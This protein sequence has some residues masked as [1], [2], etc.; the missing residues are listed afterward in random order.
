MCTKDRHTHSTA[1]RHGRI[2]GHCHRM[3]SRS[4]VHQDKVGSTISVLLRA[5]GLLYPRR[6]VDSKGPLGMDIMVWTLRRCTQVRASPSP[7]M[8]A[9]SRDVIVPITSTAANGQRRN[10]EV[11][12]W[13]LKKALFVARFIRAV[14]LCTTMTQGVQRDFQQLYSNG[15]P[16]DGLSRPKL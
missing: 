3:H 9:A 2:S 14:L 1:D 4:Y 13:W 8:E 7:S 5:T 12:P 6:F 15:S 10:A 16:E 11:A